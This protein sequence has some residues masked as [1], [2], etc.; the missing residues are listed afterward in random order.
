SHSLL[1]AHDEASRRLSRELHDVFSQ[2]LAALATESRLLKRDLPR[3]ETTAADRA[4]GLALRITKLAKDMHQM[5]RHLHPA[6][7]D[8]LGLQVALRAEC[9]AFSQ[10]HGIPTVFRSKRPIQPLNPGVA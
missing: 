4:E 8:E 2:E 9:T 3:Q 7:L 1:T 6:V 5:S 10:A